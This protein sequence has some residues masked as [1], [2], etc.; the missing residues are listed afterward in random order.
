MMGWGYSPFGWIGMGFMW[1]IPI[2]FLVLTV[3]GIVWLV[4]SV[5]G[6]APT[7]ACPSCGRGVQADWRNCPHCGAALS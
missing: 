5:G 6:A 3:L 4:R 2:G 1:L 7:R